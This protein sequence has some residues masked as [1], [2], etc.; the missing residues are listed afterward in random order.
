VVIM[1]HPCR[2][3]PSQVVLCQ[4]DHAIHAFPPSCAQEPLAERV[5]LWTL[6]W[7]FQTVSPSL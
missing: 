4:R 1:L 7:G 5:R 2:Q 3:K 6:G